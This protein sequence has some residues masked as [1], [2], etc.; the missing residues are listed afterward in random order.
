[1]LQQVGMWPKVFLAA[2]VLQ[3]A[4][5]GSRSGLPL[6]TPEIEGGSTPNAL[7]A[8]LAPGAIVT[9]FSGAIQPASVGVS[10]G[11]LVVAEWPFTGDVFRMPKTG[12]SI[13][14]TISESEAAV[15]QLVADAQGA[16][17]VVQGFGDTDGALRG[18]RAGA[19]QAS[20]LVG[21]LTRPQG[22]AAFGDYLYFT[23][24]IGPPMNSSNGRVLRW[25]RGTVAPTVL[26][27]GM[28][29]PWAIAVDA[30]GVYFTHGGG[31]FALP[32]TGGVPEQLTFGEG[33][34]PHL[35]T[36][37]QRLYWSDSGGSLYRRD[38]ATTEVQQI[39]TG[40]DRIEGIAADAAGAYLVQ[41]TA[42]SDVATGAVF[43][44]RNEEVELLAV[45]DHAPLGLALDVSAIYFVA[46]DGTRGSVNMLCR[47]P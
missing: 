7:C 24:G 8:E 6:P 17:W 4:A 28:T 1:M 3:M 21:S 33:L 34:L 36:D 2:L 32:L 26:A 44:I 46:L 19:S 22:L 42:P 20:T 15:N 13:S 27:S 5:C 23:D 37:G 14:T 10:G 12:G 38:H 30:T 40:L 11:Q 35:A 47:E 16:H 18:A 39:A 43:A 41:R 31:V 25:R 29:N 45:T 9:L